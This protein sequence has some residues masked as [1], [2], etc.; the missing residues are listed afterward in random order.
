MEKKAV[1]NLAGDKYS[2]CGC[3]ACYSVCPVGAISMQADKK[4]FLYPQI[5]E[6]ICVRCQKCMSVCAFKVDLKI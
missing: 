4:G 3:A 5:D 1:P 6:D 2:C